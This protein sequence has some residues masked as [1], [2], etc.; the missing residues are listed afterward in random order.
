MYRVIPYDEKY[1]RIVDGM[2]DA[3]EYGRRGERCDLRYS[4]AR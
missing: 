4:C 2:A 1:E 3:V